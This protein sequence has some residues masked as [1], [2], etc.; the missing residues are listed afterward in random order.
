MPR[1]VLPFLPP[2]SPCPFLRRFHTFIL[3]LGSVV[4]VR[5]R[6]AFVRIERG[7]GVLKSASQGG[8]GR[9]GGR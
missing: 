5:E 2:S 1:A 9:S 3:D 6:R 7:Y 8:T 4:P